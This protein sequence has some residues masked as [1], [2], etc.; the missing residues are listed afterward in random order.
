MM[1]GSIEGPLEDPYVVPLRRALPGPWLPAPARKPQPL[2]RGAGA[3]A[4]LDPDTFALDV[5]SVDADA[6]DP[7]R[8]AIAKAICAP[9]PLR[10]ACLAYA[11][12]NE[13]YGIW[14]GLDADERLLLRGTP[15]VSVEERADAQW[16]R[17]AFERGMAAGEVAA[18]L[19][20]TRRTVE[21]W[22]SAAGLTQ[23]RTVGAPSGAGSGG[24][25]PAMADARATERLHDLAA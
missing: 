22:R 20:V 10:A 6:E 24:E 7:E 16:I 19:G 5:F 13:P 1:A 15:L 18:I 23:V 8:A 12:E 4:G 3:C 14:G 11:M 9:C 17:D 25:S 2:N 21:R